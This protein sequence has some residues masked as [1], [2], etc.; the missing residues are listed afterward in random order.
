VGGAPGEWSKL[1]EQE[2][3]GKQ[4]RERLAAGPGT[5]THCLAVTRD[6]EALLHVNRGSRGSPAPICPHVGGCSLRLLW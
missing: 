5:A 3:A 2:L 6:E 4:S 1:G